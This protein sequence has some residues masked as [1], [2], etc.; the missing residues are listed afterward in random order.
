MNITMKRASGSQLRVT[1]QK[2]LGWG[3]G[4]KMQEQERVKSR[5]KRGMIFPVFLAPNY[6]DSDEIGSLGRG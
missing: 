6:Q 4:E 3:K 2:S 1:Y 5:S